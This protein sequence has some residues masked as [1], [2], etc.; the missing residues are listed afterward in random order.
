[1]KIKPY[2]D[3]LSNSKEYKQFSEQYKDAFL[4]AGFFVID[5]ESDRKIHQ[6]DYYIPS[7]KKIAAFTLDDKLNLQI[8]D[9]VNKST[10]EKLDIQTKIDLE[11]LKGILEDEMKNRGITEDIKKMIVILQTI[12]GQKVWNVNCVLSGMDILKAHVDDDSKTVL[13]MDK[14]SIMDYVKKMPGLA[15][16]MQAQQMQMSQDPEEGGSQV[17]P[18]QPQT[19]TQTQGQQQ[20]TSNDVEKKIQQLDKVKQL[21]E[22]KKAELEKIESAKKAKPSKIVKKK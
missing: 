22:Q 21:L 12:K 10:P 8:L 7:K 1:M 20:I 4:V 18:Q 14:S 6:I 17:S 16:G 9:A 2:V 5:F 15:G 13:R 3:K 11:A 19:Q